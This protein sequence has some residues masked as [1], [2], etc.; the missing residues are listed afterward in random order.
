MKVLAGTS[1]WSY[2]PWKGPFYPE[3][4]PS[5]DMLS[6]YASRLPTVEVN[7]TFYRMPSVDQLR[8]WAEETPAGFFFAV[9]S[10]QRITH[11]LRLAD[12]REA[13]ERFATAARGF[14]DRLGPLLF[15]LPPFL[16]KD[17]ERLAGFLA[18]ARE[19]GPDLRL[20]FEFRHASWFDDEVYDRLRAAGAALCIAEDAKLATPLVATASW[21]YLRLRREDYQETDVATWAERVVGQPWTEAFV[22]FKHE[23]AGIGPGLAS[24]LLA[25]LG[26]RPA[27]P[28]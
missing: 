14:A 3:K 13:F 16:K 6:F 25:R 12:A 11:Q 1:G 18:M 8:R 23:D 24:A 26:S 9:K 27:A 15:Q 7:N 28:A 4:L 21:G 22:Y 2:A 17:V 10:P 19:V 5:S 20:A